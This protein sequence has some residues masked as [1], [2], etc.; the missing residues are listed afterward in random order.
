MWL[1]PNLRMSLQIDTVFKVF[2]LKV[3]TYLKLLT[4]ISSTVCKLLFIWRRC[5]Y[6]RLSSRIIGQWQLGNWKEFSKEAV[7]VILRCYH[8]LYLEW[9]RAIIITLEQ[10]NRG[11]CQ[12]KSQMPYYLLTPCTKVLPE[13]MTGSQLVKK[14]P[15]FYGTRGFIAILTSSPH[16]SLTWKYPSRSEACCMNVS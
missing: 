7:V 16:L 1:S 10:D 14:F 3:P 8:G 4:L 12:D 15:T 11:L 2:P 13:N 6:P 5:R 9:P